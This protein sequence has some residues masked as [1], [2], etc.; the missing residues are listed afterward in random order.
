M[1]CS[2]FPP[3]LPGLTSDGGAEA[4]GEGGDEAET[5]TTE[6]PK[7][8]PYLTVSPAA[9]A[10]AFYTSAFGARQKVLMPA[11]DGMRIMHCE[12]EING[13]SV[14]LADAFPEFG[15]AR[16]PLPGEPATMSVSLEFDA[17]RDVDDIVTR[18]A[19]LGATTELGPM[20]TFWGTRLAVLRDPFG[21]RWMLNGPT[22][23]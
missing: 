18:A 20:N 6:R 22:S 4:G 9:A 17:A 8:A 5:M 21:H 13:G 23:G 1:Q 7:V 14:M 12:L 3:E 2:A 15:K 19:Q 10:I 11:V 16:T